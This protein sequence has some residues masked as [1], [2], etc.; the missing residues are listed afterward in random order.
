MRINIKIQSKNNVILKSTQERSNGI[1]ENIIT[2]C[3]IS[4]ESSFSVL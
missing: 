1:P 2:H 4:R 3:Q